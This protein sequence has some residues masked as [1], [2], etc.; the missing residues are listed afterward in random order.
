M[1]ILSIIPYLE[2]IKRISLLRGYVDVSVEGCKR[3]YLP[4]VDDDTIVVYPEIIRGNFLK[5]KNVVRWFLFFNRFPN[6]E[7]AYGKNDLIFS[8]SKKFNDPKLNPECRICTVSYFNW[9][10]YKRTNFGTREGTCYIVRKG[11]NR[12]D[13]PDKFDGP[14]I[15]KFSERGK[16]DQFNKC[17]YCVSYDMYTAYSSIAA[18]L[19]CISIVIPEPGKTK[20]DYGGERLGVAFGFDEAEIEHAQSTLDELAERYRNNEKRNRENVKFFIEECRKYFDMI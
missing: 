5:A 17:K 13:L 20:Q 1:K 10:L 12:P 15:D 19:G 3:K 6:D 4:F 2:C 16:V 7:N 18:M 11:A 8:Y 9:N 14:V